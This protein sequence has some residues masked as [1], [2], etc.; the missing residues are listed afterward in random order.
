MGQ[1]NRQAIEDLYREAVALADRAR[2]W[3]DGPGAKWRAKLPVDAQAQVATESLGVTSRL[4]MVMSWLLD[5]AHATDGA[6][7]RAFAAEPSDIATPAPLAGTKGGEIVVASRQ[8]AAR[9]AAMTGE[10]A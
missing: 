6:P 9:I 7:L 1:A 8:L 3:F 5:P 10:S 4:M 2:A